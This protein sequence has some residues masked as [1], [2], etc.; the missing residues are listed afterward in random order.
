ML[1]KSK[2]DVMKSEEIK[3]S[4]STMFYMV[5]MMSLFNEEPTEE[6]LIKLCDII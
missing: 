1:G 4:S 2:Y 6:T 5:K 3:L